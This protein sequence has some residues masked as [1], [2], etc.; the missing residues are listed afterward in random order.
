MR[1]AEARFNTNLCGHVPFPLFS[2]PWDT[3]CVGNYLNNLMA[4]PRNFVVREVHTAQDGVTQIG[5]GNTI[6]YAD[7]VETQRNIQR[8][9]ASW[10]FD[11][12]NSTQRSQARIVQ[13]KGR[14]IKGCGEWLTHDLVP[15]W[16]ADGSD[17]LWIYGDVGSGKS[18]LCSLLIS[19]LRRMQPEVGTLLVVPAIFSFDVDYTAR[20]EFLPNTIL[21]WLCSFDPIP[22]PVKRA[23]ETHLNA[24]EIHDIDALIEKTIAGLDAQGAEVGKGSLTIMLVLDAIDEVSYDQQRRTLS[25]INALVEQNKTYTAVRFRAVLFTRNDMR[26]KELCPTEEGWTHQQIPEDSL[27]SDILT[28][29]Q[30]RLAE[31]R[32][33]MSA[34][35]RH[36]L[37][38]TVGDRAGGMFRLAGLYV[39]HLLKP[40]Q[41]KLSSTQLQT[42]INALPND[43]YDFYDRIISKI[44]DQEA[45]RLSFKSLR[46]IFYASGVMSL[47][48]IA[49]ACS[50]SFPGDN[51]YVEGLI[52]EVDPLDIVDPLSG[53]I[54]INPPLPEDTD[55]LD[56]EQHRITIAH[57][58]VGEYLM[59]RVHLSFDVRPSFYQQYDASLYLAQAAFCYLGSYLSEPENTTIGA[60]PLL[61][62]AAD[63]WPY[64][65]AASIHPSHRMSECCSLNINSLAL[66]VRNCFAYPDADLYTDAEKL[67]QRV[68]DYMRA[69][70]SEKQVALLSSRLLGSA[71]LASMN[72]SDAPPY[73][74][75]DL[76][77]IRFVMLYPSSEENVNPRCELFTCSLDNDPNYDFIAWCWQASA[78][79]TEIP[80]AGRKVRTKASVI[81]ALIHLQCRLERPQAIWVDMLCINRDDDA[82]RTNQIQQIS[83]TATNAR[84]VIC[85]LDRKYSA[86]PSLPSFDL[87]SNMFWRRSWVIQEL[88]LA[89]QIT[90]MFGNQSWDWQMVVPLLQSFTDNDVV[91][92]RRSRPDLITD[93]IAGAVKAGIKTIDSVQVIR[94]RLAEGEVVN[95]EELLSTFCHMRAP[96]LTDKIASLVSFNTEH[97]NEYQ[98]LIDYSV[99]FTGVYVRLAV[100]I[101]ESR[102]TLDLLAFNNIESCPHGLP[103]WAPCWVDPIFRDPLAPGVFKP[104]QPHLFQASKK[105]PRFDFREAIS[106]LHIYGLLV[107]EIAT[108][109]TRDDYIRR[110]STKGPDG[111]PILSR[112]PLPEF[113]EVYSWTDN[114]VPISLDF[115]EVKTVNCENSEIARALTEGRTIHHYSRASSILENADKLRLDTES[116]PLSR[117][118]RLICETKMGRLGNVPKRARKGD[119]VVVLEG[120][121]TPHVLR[122]FGKVGGKWV[123]YELV[124]ECYVDGLMDGEAEQVKEGEQPV[125]PVKFVIE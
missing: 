38:K 11:D 34:S 28:A 46:W 55:D 61:K 59:N 9:F 88:V 47:G 29:V 103:T 13:E 94:K 24:S 98:S 17:C 52:S 120:A 84:Q 4:V 37:A 65:V 79:E 106:E 114:H 115:Q 71:S 93:G 27:E 99:P 53:F 6:N 64:H 15:Q 12:P 16:L 101:M 82:E 41:R 49:E 32:L 113:S 22:T 110:A 33:R 40:N 14:A 21:A 26:V 42:I 112:L 5:H 7:P 39:D 48:E 80:V 118:D 58:S 81:D 66:K 122:P 1:I 117:A 119:V 97:Y 50:R 102:K 78:P 35:E 25:L 31:S 56:Y 67:R 8:W 54:H 87:Y 92:A 95:L 124:G 100:T 3:F 69:V 68:K 51:E 72:E 2:P 96:N 70:L 89:K 86:P 60:W 104:D 107:D 18:I 111:N 73:N 105:Q 123:T 77:Q 36:S 108:T 62:Y 91:S 63:Q 125:E 76:G 116:L 45:R 90:I 75:L 74:T 23:R 30:G 57:F 10:L 121:R 44:E 85:W 83:S 109:W 43:L 20:S 19:E